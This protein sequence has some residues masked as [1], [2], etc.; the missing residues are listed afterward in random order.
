M[1]NVAI[2]GATSAI[3]EQVARLFAAEGARIYLVARRADQL[4]RAFGL[5]RGVACAGP[6]AGIDSAG[7]LP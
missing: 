7:R 4:E 5:G 3:A 6:A 1:K 2:F